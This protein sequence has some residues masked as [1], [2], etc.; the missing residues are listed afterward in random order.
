MLGPIVAVT[1]TVTDLAPVESAY[2][3]YLGYKVVE[4]GQ[5]PQD[6]A[7]VW[8]APK[9][10]GRAYMIMQPESGA[11]CY[12]RFVVVDPYPDYKPLHT[13]GWNSTELLVTDVDAVHESLKG[14]PFEVVGTPRGLSSNDSIK[15]MQVMGPANEFLYLT[16]IKDEAMG[17]GT[18][19]S[20]VDRP[21]IVINGG[22]DMAELIGFYRD[23]LK[24]KVGEPQPVRMTALNKIR[25][26]DPETKH[27][28]STVDVGGP[29]LIEI[30]QYPPGTTMRSV[31]AGDLP[32]G[33]A[34]VTFEVAKLDAVPV[35]LV[36]GAKVAQGRPYNGRRIGV[37]R[38]TSNELHE[39]VETP[40]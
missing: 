35:P 15:A 24:N 28:L 32:P 20:F 22:R 25:G 8:G 6:L 11:N 19:K 33:T 10:A 5:V 29:F 13:Y 4:R 23:V 40:Q 30:D 14:S 26:F 39:L 3:K 12:L 9:V 36:A 37:I 17:L 34:M 1:M 21:F 27:P 18:A 2:A 31:R 16:T 7:E 38:G